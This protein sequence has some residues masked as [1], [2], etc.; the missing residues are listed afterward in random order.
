MI[1]PR[2]FSSKHRGVIEQ[3]IGLG[4]FWVLGR[5]V[6]CKTCRFSQW[7]IHHSGKLFGEYVL[8]FSSPFYCKSTIITSKCTLRM[9]RIN[10]EFR[11]MSTHLSIGLWLLEEYPPN[12]HKQWLINPRL[13]LI[14]YWGESI[15]LWLPLPKVFRS[16]SL[17]DHG[18]MGAD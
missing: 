8:L 1:K 17:T 5:Q 12:F 9:N 14:H 11:I 7:R 15:F 6:D 2:G 13:T 3:G 18:D 4:D 10:L 16:T